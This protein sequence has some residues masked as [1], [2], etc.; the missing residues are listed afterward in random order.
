MEWLKG[1]ACA[2]DFAAAS[3]VQPLSCAHHWKTATAYHIESV[4]SLLV[5]LYLVTAVSDPD[6]G[7]WILQQAHDLCFRQLSVALVI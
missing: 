7:A 3:V 2:A 6:K 5:A 1:S 4:A